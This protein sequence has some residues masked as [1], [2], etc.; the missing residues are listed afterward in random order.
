[1]SDDFGND[2]DIQTHVMDA[3]QED[4]KP[5]KT[6]E[7]KAA[8]EFSL[9]MAPLAL[10]G[11][12][13]SVLGLLALV[14]SEGEIGWVADLCASLRCQV[15]IILLISSLPFLFTRSLR[16]V[17][18][19]L[20]SLALINVGLVCTLVIPV[21]AKADA[22]DYLSFTV[23][24]TKLEDSN[25]KSWEEIVK[26]VRDLGPDI[27]CVENL[28][29]DSSRRINEQLP[30]WHRGGEFPDAKG[31]GLGIFCNHPMSNIS[32]KKLGPDNLPAVFASCKFEFGECNLVALSA[33][34]PSDA[35]SFKK[36][37][38]YLDAVVQEVTKLKGP[39]VV[40][41]LFNMSPYGASFSKVTKAGNLTDGREGNGIIP[42]WHWGPTDI[43]INRFPVDHFLVS[44][45][46]EVQKFDVKPNALGAS[47]APIMG[48]FQ[49]QESAATQSK[50]APAA[51]PS[52]D[53]AAAPAPA[54]ASGKK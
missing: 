29:A 45:E 41:G 51:A 23:Y 15:I 8:I 25:K 3:A 19:F 35:A 34:P 7:S 12:L 46:I 53:S 28:D 54:E 26:Q 24:Q 30:Y 6:K 37:N 22:K 9:M 33:P 13:L 10:V 49:I 11:I 50:A 40:T 5:A 31:T 43:V 32:C 42:N 4:K 52:K 21:H 38:Q 18:A 14:S 36:R 20:I 47:H 2:D 16:L 48:K 39:V 27:F 1:M 17:S 44:K